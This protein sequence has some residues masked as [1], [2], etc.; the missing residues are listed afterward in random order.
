MFRAAFPLGSRAVGPGHPCLVVAEVGA[1]HAGSG[2]EAVRMVEA[3]FSMGADT[4]L[5]QVYRTEQLVVSRHPQRR[6]LERLELKEREWRRVLS[7]ARASGLGLIVEAL[8]RPSVALAAEAGADG[9]QVHAG[10]IDH[11]DLLRT[12][13]ATGRPVFLCAQGVGEV[14]FAEARAVL[15]GGPLALVHGPLGTPAPAEELR[16]LEM[17]SL[18][19]RHHLPVGFRDR[20]DASSAFSLVA[21]AVAVAFGAD[22]VHKP[23]TLDRSRTGHD[24][25][26]ALQPEDFHRMVEL[27]RQGESARGDAEGQAAGEAT[28]KRPSSRSVVA[29]ALIPRGAV[30]VAELL[31]FKRTDER[32]GN[33]LPPRE[34][35]RLIGRRARRPIQA[36]EV[37]REDMLE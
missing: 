18:R 2:D 33:G 28:S 19:D 11:P 35:D 24:E 31:A 32:F 13:A 29:G 21:P 10:D 6:A 9:L 36:D 27:L 37:L 22:F 20:T 1:A 25:P 12:V 4:I 14:A 30:L 23:F 26:C 17:G 5:F 8:D 7:A 34:A 15:T 16:L 3:A